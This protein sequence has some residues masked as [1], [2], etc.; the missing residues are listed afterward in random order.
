MAQAEASKNTPDKAHLL[1]YSDVSW[2]A[3]IL[4]SA[5]DSF[6]QDGSKN[7]KIEFECTPGFMSTYS[8][9]VQKQSEAGD[10]FLTIVQ[11][12]NILDSVGTRAAYGI[13]SLTGNCG[14]P[15]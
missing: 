9:S 3:T 12:E 6:T 11:N 15:G 8:L 14:E 13:A 7:S 4:D 5:L 10:L 2:S 1:I